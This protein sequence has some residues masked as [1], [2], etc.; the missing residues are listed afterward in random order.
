MALMTHHDSMTQ[1][2][3]PL[4]RTLLDLHKGLIDGERADYEREHGAV[5]PAEML[6]LLIGDDRF[7]W[8]QPISALIVRVDELLSNANGRRRPNTARP[9]MTPEQVTAEATALVR[10][11]R[12]LLTNG[13]A[14]GGFHERY[15]AA[16]Q[17][18]P[19]IVLMHQAVLDSLDSV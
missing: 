13:E 12:E 1:V 11:T 7:S 10:E 5:S 2:L 16:L 14:P 4:R 3:T 15:N 19:A 17:R 9:A 8:L 18:D 6:R